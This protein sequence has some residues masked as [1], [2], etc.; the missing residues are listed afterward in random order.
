MLPDRKKVG[1]PYTVGAAL[2]FLGKGSCSPGGE[3]DPAVKN[4]KGTNNV[5]VVPLAGRMVHVRRRFI[6]RAEARPIE[7]MV[8]LDGEVLAMFHNAVP[9]EQSESVIFKG[10]HG[11]ILQMISRN[12]SLNRCVLNEISGGARKKMR[13]KHA[14]RHRHAHPHEIEAL[15]DQGEEPEAQPHQEAAFGRSRDLYAGESLPH[16]HVQQSVIFQHGSKSGNG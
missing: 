15:V 12:I 7:H 3:R 6:F 2:L 13:S 10:R 1:F 9:V 11:T 16:L 4:G 14:Y 8:Y 5:I